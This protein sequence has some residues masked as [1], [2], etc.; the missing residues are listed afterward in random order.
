MDPASLSA[1]FH[2]KVGQVNA[3][4][5]TKLMH[6][7]QSLGRR[8]HVACHQHTDVIMAVKVDEIATESV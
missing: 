2:K 6:S 1:R 4:L 8:W 7:E 5:G 3:Q